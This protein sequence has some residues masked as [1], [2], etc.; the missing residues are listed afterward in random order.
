MKLN[1]NPLSSIDPLLNQ[2]AWQEE[3]RQEEEINLI[4]SEN[5]APHAIR[6]IVSSALTNKYAEGYP[7]KRYYGGCHIVDQIEQL[8]IDRAKTL[9]G[10]DHA[11][12]QPHAGSQ[13]NMAAYAALLKPGDLILGMSLASGGHLT[14][15]HH[16]N[17]SGSFYKS[18]QYGV[19]RDTEHLDYDELE[20]LAHQHKPKLIIAGASAY[21]R[22]IDFKRI[23]AIADSV[24]AFFLADIAHIAGLIA[25]GLH[26]SPVAYADMVSGTT[27]KTLRGPRGGFILSSA[28]HKETLDRAVLP[29][30]QGG[31]LLHVIAAKALA[32]KLASTKEFVAYQK[33]VIKNASIMA[34]AFSDRGYRVVAGGTDNHLFMLDLT[35]KKITGRVAEQVLEQAGITVSR[36]CIPFDTQKPSIT[37]GIRIGSAAITSRGMTEH[38]ALII[39]DLICTTL[40]NCENEKALEHVKAASKALCKQFPIYEKRDYSSIMSDLKTQ[41]A[42]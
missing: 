2:L 37:S 16:V 13:A 24:N 34:Q 41:I 28:A 9:F 17:F 36:S 31:P 22:T 3:L 7:Q 20:K 38:E 40:E 30:L 35:S 42:E 14:H 11:N 21:S 1:N 19:D 5:Y 15:G 23:R 12:V 18:I 26:P 39:V 29:G 10:S 6:E 32:F 8:A 27:H 25:A 33:N 4:A